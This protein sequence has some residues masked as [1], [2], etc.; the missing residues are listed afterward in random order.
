M[1]GREAAECIEGKKEDRNE[2]RERQGREKEGERVKKR[3][4]DK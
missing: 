3:R 4:K 1:N 2:E